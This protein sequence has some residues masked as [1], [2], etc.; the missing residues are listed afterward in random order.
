ML[1]HDLSIE[2]LGTCFIFPTSLCS[3]QSSFCR[4]LFLYIALKIRV[5]KK[6]LIGKS[7]SDKHKCPLP[8]HLKNAGGC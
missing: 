3:R 4:G 6:K 1:V 7:K 8:P 5:W 2:C